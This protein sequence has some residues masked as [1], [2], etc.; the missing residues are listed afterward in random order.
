[1]KKYPNVELRYSTDLNLL[2]HSGDKEV[3]RSTSWNQVYF[4]KLI[5]NVYAF[6]TETMGQ[7]IILNFTHRRNYS[8]K[9]MASMYPPGFSVNDDDPSDITELRESKPDVFIV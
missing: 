1:M 6:F 3:L 8:G 9:A 4:E 5:E 2:L 7:E